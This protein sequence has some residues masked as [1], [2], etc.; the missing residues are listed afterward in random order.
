MTAKNIFSGRAP[1]RA[2]APTH[3]ALVTPSDSTD[4]SY[5]SQL[6]YVGSA[7]TLH[8]TTVGGETLITPTLT[9]GWHPMELSRIHATGTTAGNLMVGW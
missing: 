3:L 5:I 1:M 4:L 2:G 9:Q 8:V 7:G 6:V